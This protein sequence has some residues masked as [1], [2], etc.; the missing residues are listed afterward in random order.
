M[1]SRSPQPSSAS[2]N[3]AEIAKKDHLDLSL[4]SPSSDH[5]E[6]DPYYNE[7]PADLVMQPLPSSAEEADFR[8]FA[9]P[10]P[11]LTPA[12]LKLRGYKWVTAKN[13]EIPENAVEGGYMERRG[14]FTGISREPLFVGRVK[15]GPTIVPGK[16]S[17]VLGGCNYTL[18]DGVE[19]VAKTYQV[20]LLVLAL[21][22]LP[23]DSSYA[24][25]DSSYG[26]SDPRLVTSTASWRDFDTSTSRRC[27]NAS[28][29]RRSPGCGTRKGLGRRSS[30]I[31]CC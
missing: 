25:I 30:W 10:E 19:R 4:S 9:I 6:I 1:P 13:G 20:G 31:Y 28:W 2:L 5:D 27:G 15:H 12:E 8:D 21:P 14:I 26:R 7:S 18:G 17:R 11:L 29:R 22:L 3:P 16:A 24:G 23:I